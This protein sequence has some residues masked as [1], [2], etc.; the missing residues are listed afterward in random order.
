[1]S[2]APLDFN[3]ALWFEDIWRDREE[4]IYPQLFG[5]L[6][7]TVIPLRAEALRGILGAN[8][9]LREDWLHYSVIEIAP[10]EKHADWLYIT[11]AFSQPWKI[12][13]PD[14]LDR[15]GYSGVGYELLLRTS[16]RAGWAVDVLHRLSAYQIG[17]YYEIMRGKLFQWGDYMPL[18]G[19]IS[20]NVP[21]GKVRGIYA[22]RPRDIEQRFELRSGQ[23]DVLQLVGITGD[24]L[25]FGLNA[26]FGRLENLLFEH[27]A[28]PTTDPARPSIPLP[29]K[30]DLP[31]QLASRF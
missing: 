23:V 18:N 4:R 11:S 5:T 20:P 31:P 7:K 8:T 21:N 24:E 10:N 19:P 12:D 25:A 22:T 2:D 1:M 30:Y 14:K 17:V 9:S 16:D 27:N 6:P 3:R 28:A 29:Q 15:N 26:G 13:D